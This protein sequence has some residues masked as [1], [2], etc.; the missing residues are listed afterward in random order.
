M[1]PAEKMQILKKR[2]KLTT[3]KL[4]YYSIEKDLY[5]IRKIKV[6]FQLSPYLNSRTLG[7]YTLFYQ[8]II[9]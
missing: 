8:Y 2:L 6:L 1:T 7:H 5:E 4:G 3:K 9:P